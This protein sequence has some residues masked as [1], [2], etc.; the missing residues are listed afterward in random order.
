MQKYVRH[1]LDLKI[2]KLK[3]IYICL[4]EL[5]ALV[6]ASHCDILLSLPVK[7]VPPFPLSFTVSHTQETA[8]VK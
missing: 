1:R 8:E 6:F 3:N 2:A 5:F 7:L 4:P